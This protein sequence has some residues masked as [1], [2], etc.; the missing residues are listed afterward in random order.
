MALEYTNEIVIACPMAHVA[1]VFSDKDQIGDWQRGF[2]S[3]KV[4]SGHPGANGS[5]AELLYLNRGKEMIMTET[6]EDNSLPHHFHGLY[7]MPGIHNVQR[8]YF[9][10]LGDGTTHWRGETEFQFSQW[11]MRI[12]G[13]LMPGMFRKTSQRFM[14][15]FKDW[16]ENGVSA[17][18]KPH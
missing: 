6:I 15:D 8:H 14:D 5:T 10:D 3:L 9:E 7:D 11:T 17:R 1:S 13:R 12:M 4:K 16:I 18:T 2:V